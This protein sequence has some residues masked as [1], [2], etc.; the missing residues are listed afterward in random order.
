MGVIFY[1]E[2]SRQPRVD[3]TGASASE[4]HAVPHRASSAHPHNRK[5]RSHPDVES[6]GLAGQLVS[7]RTTGTGRRK[8]RF[9]RHKMELS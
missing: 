3:I 1:G 6:G 5:N 9:N 7:A 8:R 4:S 2:W